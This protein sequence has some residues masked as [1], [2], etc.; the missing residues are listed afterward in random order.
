MV[1][2]ETAGIIGDAREVAFRWKLFLRLSARR[3]LARG[4]RRAA[5]S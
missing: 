4:P 2:S 3:M 5:A 1:T